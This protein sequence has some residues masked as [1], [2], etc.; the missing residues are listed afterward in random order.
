MLVAFCAIFSNFSFIFLTCCCDS[1]REEEERWRKRGGAVF[2]LCEGHVSLDEDV[3]SHFWKCLGVE[4][5]VVLFDLAKPVERI[6]SSLQYSGES[7][8]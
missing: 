2:L 5:S 4:E 1:R 8:A 7:Q 3:L 6:R